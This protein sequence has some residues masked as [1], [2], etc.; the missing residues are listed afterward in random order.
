MHCFLLGVS[1]DKFFLTYKKNEN[2]RTYFLKFM[3]VCSFRLIFNDCSFVLRKKKGSNF[4]DTES[5]YF[6][7][8][9][10]A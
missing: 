7:I 1:S 10:V 9:L 8:V 6:I 5:G 2:K 4:Y 3:H